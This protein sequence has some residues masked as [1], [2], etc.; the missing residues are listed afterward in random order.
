MDVDDR[1][2]AFTLE[3]FIASLLVLT[4]LLLALQSI[5]IT[6]T[7]TGSVD[8]AVRSDLRQQGSDVLE[9]SASNG[10]LS[11]LARFWT[12][13]CTDRTFVDGNGEQIGYGTDRVPFVLGS[14]LNETF[15]ERGRTYNV[16]IDYEL[17]K[18]DDTIV[19]DSVPVARRGAPADN[20]I[21]V[22]YTVTLYDDQILT[23]PDDVRIGEAFE[24]CESDPGG[25]PI[26]DAHPDS[27]VYNVIQFRVVVW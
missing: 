22:R 5:V 17:N 13:D 3:G 23:G 12:D 18:T 1:G 16:F 15:T 20:A 26:P 4:A 8:P 24:D 14:L 10:T 6:P 21:V 19:Y 27:E 2:Q 9:V 11:K 7:T 25:F